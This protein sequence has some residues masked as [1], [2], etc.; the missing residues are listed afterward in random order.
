MPPKRAG[1]FAVMGILTLLEVDSLF[2]HHDALAPCIDAALSPAT[3]P[4][5]GLES[6]GHI[7]LADRMVF[8]S[9][10]I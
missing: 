8:D 10:C 9:Q 3:L 7:Q 6:T 4:F 5:D 2:A 1:I